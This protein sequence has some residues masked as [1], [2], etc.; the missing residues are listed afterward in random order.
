M[1]QYG[2]STMSG[3]P[4]FQCLVPHQH[5]SKENI[6]STLSTFPLCIHRADKLSDLDATKIFFFI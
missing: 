4:W 2:N 1:W 3:S 5:T 6:T